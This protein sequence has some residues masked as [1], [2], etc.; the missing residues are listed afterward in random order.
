MLSPEIRSQTPPSILITGGA[1]FIGSNLAHSLMRDGHSVRIFDNLSRRGVDQ[2]LEWLDC[3]HPGQ[4]EFVRGDVRDFAV[5]QDAVQDIGT[6][7]HFASQVAV[8]TSVTDP[9]TDFEVNALGAF[10]V[11]EAARLSGNRPTIGFTST[12]KVYG[13]MDDV[14]IE[15]KEDRYVFRDYPNGISEARPLDFHSPYGCSKGAADQYM[16]DYA[17][18]YGLP[19]F[20]F[21]MSCIYGTR[22]FG[23]EDQGWVAFM[24]IAAAMNRSLNIYGDGKQVR[25]ILWVEDLVQ[26]FRLAAEHIDLTAGQ[27]YNVGG[28]AA[29]A[30]SIWAEFGRI[31]AELSGHE[32]PVTYKGWR[33]GDQLVYVSD[34]TKIKQ[35]LGWEPTTSKYQGIETLFR[36]VSSNKELFE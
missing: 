2:N 36:W 11:L 18:I 7:F 3:M 15:E 9:R 17:R 19:T 20:V 1:G 10:N 5:V 22:Q 14:V 21:R 25:D 29:N 24:V 16:R 4:V 31:L 32:V 26:A 30:L 28:G 27:V 12:N 34:S 8:T 35:T 13:G 33:P 23:I 6:I